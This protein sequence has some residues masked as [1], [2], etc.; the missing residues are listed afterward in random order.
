MRPSFYFL[1]NEEYYLGNLDPTCNSVYPAYYLN[2]FA[3]SAIFGGTK[4]LKLMTL[5]SAPQAT[6]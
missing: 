1:C 4:N 2:A 3:L 6:A 5:V